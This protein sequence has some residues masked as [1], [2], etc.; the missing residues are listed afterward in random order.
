M[1]GILKL[2]EPCV[3]QWKTAVKNMLPTQTT[4]LLSRA[5]YEAFQSTST[6]ILFSAISA[7]KKRPLA[8]CFASTRESG[9][10]SIKK[11]QLAR[12]V[13]SVEDLNNWILFYLIVN[14]WLWCKWCV[15]LIMKEARL[16]SSSK[17]VFPVNN[18]LPLWR[19][20]CIF[21]SSKNVLHIPLAPTST[22]Q[23]L[24]GLDG[25]V[26]TLACHCQAGAMS[27]LQF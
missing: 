20:K 15:N 21:V 24:E 18:H 27:R 13:D 3:S 8:L 4:L 11:Q 2:W 12:G 22:A 6:A 23:Y 17:I 25:F 7:G 14:V 26:H 16:W 1:F 10:V 5:G 9:S 19:Q